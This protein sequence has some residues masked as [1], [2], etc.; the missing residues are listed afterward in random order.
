MK[1]KEYGVIDFIK[2]DF[3]VN[4][5][6][7]PNSESE[8]FWREYVA[9]HPEMIPVINQAK[10]F[11]SSIRYEDQAS[12]EPFEYTEMFENIIKPGQSDHKLKRQRI[13]KVALKVAAVISVFLVVS[14]VYL[15]IVSI[16][17]EAIDSKEQVSEIVKA[18]PKGQKSTI[19][20]PDG[21]KVKLNSE[22]TLTFYSDFKTG[23][24]NVRLKGEAFFDVTTDI[25]RPFTIK[26]KD[27]E[28]KVKGTSFNVRSYA[29]ED[30]TQV[31]VVSGE[32]S[33]SDKRGNSI[34]L[35]PNEFVEYSSSKNTIKKSVDVDFK[36]IIGW[37]DGILIFEND[38]I[39]LV[40][41]KIE[42]WYGV[43]IILENNS[44]I[45]GTYTGEYHNK[46]LQK[47]LDGISYASNVDFKI[48]NK[49]QIL[50]KKKND[51]V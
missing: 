15:N 50:I 49:T 43:E 21:S 7:N 35:N 8:E 30:N 6:Q 27:I 47:V 16:S 2:D 23:D 38:P 26:T 36:K 17:Q 40:V 29:D 1:Y 12:V 24:R 9:S 39:N 3:F 4:W 22:S 48:I 18:N 41:S 45:D 42:R 31:L 10:H 13:F 25:Q 37:K 51:H 33:V 46:S 11:V 14:F 28:T 5:V 44:V 20:M 19:F 32:V 34:R